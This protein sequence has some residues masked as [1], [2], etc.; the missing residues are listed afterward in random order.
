M[1]RRYG[2]SNTGEYWDGTEQ[3]D[4]YY[5]PIPHFGFDLALKHSPDL[6]NIP[7]LRPKDL[8]RAATASAAEKE[9]EGA[10]AAGGGGGGDDYDDDG[11]GGGM[12]DL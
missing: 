10:A 12:D 9:G 6:Y 5:N 1:R 2:S 7:L 11:L 4:T 8:K 3:M